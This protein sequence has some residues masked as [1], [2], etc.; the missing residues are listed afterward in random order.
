MENGK[1]ESYH[2]LK[3]KYDAVVKQLELLAQY[4]RSPAAKTFEESLV[5]LSNEVMQLNGRIQ[6]LEAQNKMLYQMRDD[7]SA[8]IIELRDRIFEYQHGLEPE[9]VALE[10]E[11]DFWRNKYLEELKRKR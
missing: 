1:E 2:E 8:K 6:E 10:A 11:R 9:K 3:L 4:K 7:N 5:G